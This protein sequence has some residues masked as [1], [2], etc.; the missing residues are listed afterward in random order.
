MLICEGKLVEGGLAWEENPLKKNPHVVHESS[1][2][3]F[4]TIGVDRINKM[5]QKRLSVYR[6]NQFLKNG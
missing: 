1:I 2:S 6:E 3:P 5:Y 4:E